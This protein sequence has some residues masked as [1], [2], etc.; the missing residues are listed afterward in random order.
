MTK[1]SLRQEVGGELLPFLLDSQRLRRI[2]LIS[3]L[4][5]IGGIPV[6]ALFPVQVAVKPC[7]V[8]I[9]EVLG[10]IMGLMPA[11]GF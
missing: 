1:L 3:T 2:W 7:P 10:D 5:P 11:P 8:G 6:I 9:R 4:I